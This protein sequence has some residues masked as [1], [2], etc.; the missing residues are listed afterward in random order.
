MSGADKGSK[1]CEEDIREKRKEAIKRGRAE[2]ASSLRTFGSSSSLIFQNNNGAQLSDI[3]DE[4]T[5]NPNSQNI[6]PKAN[7]PR[8]PEKTLPAKRIDTK[9]REELVR[10]IIPSAKRKLPL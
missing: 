4:L 5:I 3:F 10:T 7:S 1:K 8:S 9:L 6:S 2:A